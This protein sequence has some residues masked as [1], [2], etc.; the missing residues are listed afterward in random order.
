M[1][2]EKFAW[3]PSSMVLPNGID[4]DD[5]VYHPFFEDGYVDLDEASGESEECLEASV[6]ASLGVSGKLRNINLSSS[7]DNSSQ[8]SSGKRKSWSW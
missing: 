5:D 7:Q 1:A 3:A 8:M 6:G 4:K 2:T